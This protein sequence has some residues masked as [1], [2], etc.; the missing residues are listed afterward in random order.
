MGASLKY[1]L[2]NFTQQKKNFEDLKRTIE[3][4]KNNMIQGLDQVKNDWKSE[5]GRTFF[6]S[7]DKDWA[8]SID[9]CI[10][11]LEDLSKAIDEAYKNYERIEADA[12]NYLKF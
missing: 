1:D 10:V 5:G 12:N 9:N 7:V 6:D 4:A 3:E 2:D 8:D 11:V